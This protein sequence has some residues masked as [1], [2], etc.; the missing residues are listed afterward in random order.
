MKI[1]KK[2]TTGFAFFAFL[3][4]VIVYSWF[5]YDDS[6]QKRKK[7][8]KS[9]TNNYA[10][11]MK[12][13]LK[14]YHF[15]WPAP[16]NE[17][18]G[19]KVSENLNQKNYYIIFDG[20]GSMSEV[21]CSGKSTKEVVAKEALVN[22]VSQIDQKDNVGLFIFDKKGAKQRA[23]L[24]KNNRDEIISEINQS[25]ASGTTPLRTS[26]K[27][28]LNELSKQAGK[29][30]EYGEYHLVVVTDGEA[31]GKRENPSDVVQAALDK[32]PIIIHTLGF[33]IGK[34]HSLN[35][36]GKIFYKSADSPK[37]LA[38]GLDSILAESEEFT[39]TEF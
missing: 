22:F 10:A 18:L 28:G 25:Y 37:E 34:N 32:T 38:A 13:E 17:K 3:T 19:Q 27:M 8:P 15:K 35:Q 7:I 6:G 14:K 1:K 21:K 30:L 2:K 26:I 29:Q 16:I 11:F 36:P 20:S 5:N 4:Y 39:V 24:G 9:K 33:C 23:P 31:S 12:A